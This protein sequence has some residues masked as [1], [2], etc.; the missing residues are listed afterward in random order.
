MLPVVALLLAL[1]QLALQLL[2]GAQLVIAQGEQLLQLVG[3]LGPILHGG[4]QGLPLAGHRCQLLVFF[5]PEP[6]LLVLVLEQFHLSALLAPA[7]LQREL[8]FSLLCPLLL[9]LLQLLLVHLAAAERTGG[10]LDGLQ[11]P[12]NAEPAEDV[13]TRRDHR[14]LQIV[15]ANAKTSWKAKVLCYA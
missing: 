15:Q 14:A 2:Q 13:G 8:H 4:E 12:L 1:F 11:T 6:P 7:L 10:R 9:D 5:E 3:I